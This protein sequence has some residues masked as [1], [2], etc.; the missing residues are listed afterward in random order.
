MLTRTVTHSGLSNKQVRASATDSD[1]TVTSQLAR[2]DG[3]TES[4]V[5]TY[6]EGRQHPFKIITYQE[7]NARALPILHMDLVSIPLL[8][9]NRVAPGLWAGGRGGGDG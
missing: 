5:P 2:G 4:Y 6:Q 8:P 3:R 7:G 9:A 1:V